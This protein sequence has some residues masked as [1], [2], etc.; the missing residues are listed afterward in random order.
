LFRFR[1]LPRPDE[2]FF[3][4]TR[5]Q[6]RRAAM[7]CAGSA[8]KGANVAK[9]T[10]GMQSAFVFVKPHANT[11]KVNELVKAKFAEV[12]I[13]ILS[14]GEIDG[15]TIDKNKYIDQHYYAIAS[16]ATLLEPKDL[17]VKTDVFKET[18]GEE[19][20]TVLSD[21]RAFNALGM[22]EKLGGDAAT[23]DK[24]WAAT[25]DGKRVKMGG[26]FYCGMIEH[27]GTKLYTFNAFFMTMREKFTAADAKIHYYVVEFDPAKLPWADFRGKVLGPTD[28]A[29]APAD[30]LRGKLHSSWESLGLKAAP[31]TGD[32]GVHASASPFEGFAERTNWLGTSY[33]DDAFGKMMLDAGLKEDVLKAWSVDPQVTLPDG[34][35]KKGSL[36]DQVEDLDLMQCLDKLKAIAATQ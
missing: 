15:P 18:F 1:V 20:D 3:S 11:E 8:S 16:K 31:N 30:S 21:G 26:G 17:P 14:D 28:P 33:T 27:E 4:H 29:A 2:K 22:K 23:L 13:S 19:W 36:F 12:G 10:E 7:G 25:Q 35:G 5:V 32:N 24:A 34:D 9:G 6:R